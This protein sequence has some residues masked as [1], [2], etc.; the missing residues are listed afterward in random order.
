M[1]YPLS[2]ALWILVQPSSL[3]LGAL[4]LGLS[5]QW[6]DRRARLG[7]S[8]MLGAALGFVAAGF[9]PLGNLVLLPLEQRFPVPVLAD[10]RAAVAA[11]IVLGGAEDGRVGRARGQL[12]LNEA[13]ERITEPVNLA[14]RFPSARLVFSGGSAD[15]FSAG[16]PAGRQIAAFWA[17]AGIAPDRILYEERSLTTYENAVE[18]RKLLNLRSGE[19][20]LLVTSAA[21]MPRSMATFRHAGFDVI[22]Y[23]VD[24]RTEGSADLWRPFTSLSSG[25][26]RLDDAAYEWAGL[27]SYRLLGR[28]ATLLPAS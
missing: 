8:L 15:F 21:H 22:A 16:Q 26:K 23:P 18:V 1:T 13:A 5:L 17:A 19:L 6:L 3:L 20:A 10:N 14:R 11:I 4:V 2:K 28:T 27:V 24:F 7:R 9:S 25:L 12:T